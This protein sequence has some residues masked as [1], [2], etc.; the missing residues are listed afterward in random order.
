MI[1]VSQQDEKHYNYNGNYVNNKVLRVVST[2]L[3][4]FPSFFV[5]F[6]LKFFFKYISTDL[7]LFFLLVLSATEVMFSPVSLLFGLYKNN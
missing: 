5:L 6:L 2:K 4:H 3:F 7:L 1:A